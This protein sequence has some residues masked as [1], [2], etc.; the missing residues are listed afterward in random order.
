M[1]PRRWKSLRICVIIIHP[2][3]VELKTAQ[4]K[5]P[6]LRKSSEAGSRGK[7]TIPEE[8]YLCDLLLEPL[9]HVVDSDQLDDT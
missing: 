7:L 6:R 2:L 3:H 5:I 8:E 4:E 9:Y 1:L